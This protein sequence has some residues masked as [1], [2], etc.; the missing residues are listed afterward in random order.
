MKA[1]ARKRDFI[2]FLPQRSQPSHGYFFAAIFVVVV[3]WNLRS[4]L[5]RQYSG[6]TRPGAR[7]KRMNVGASRKRFSWRKDA[8]T[9]SRPR[10][11]SFVI[12]A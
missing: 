9:F 2:S 11:L 12:L 5:R 6:R 1:T 4:R 10:D 8:A 3:V 7:W